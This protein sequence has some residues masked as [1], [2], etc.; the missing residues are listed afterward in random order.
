M[1]I[2]QL[3]YFVAVAE[4]QSFTK[5]ATQFFISQTAITQ[6]IH[7]LE[8][9]IGL[10]LIDRS[11]RPISLTPGGNVFFAEAKSILSHMDMAVWRSREAS[12]GLMG[13]L[14]VG[15]TKGYEQSHLPRW[16]REFHRK[17][18]NILVTCYRNDTDMLAAGLLNQEYDIIFTWDST[19]IR[20][21]EHLRIHHAETVPLYVAMYTSHP[22][23]RR[24]ALT[25]EDLKGETIL[26]MSPS[27]SGD[28]FGDAYYIQ[29]YQ[30]A[31]YQ[32]NILLRTSDY[33]SI[34]MMIAA[35]QAISIV[36]EYCVSKL[37]SVDN[38]SFCPLEGEGETEEVLAVWDDRNTNPALQ[39]FTKMLDKE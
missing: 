11:T 8:E 28:S 20:Q 13:T 5:A 26:F 14:R 1:N 38:I 36:P 30:N 2:N 10:K 9:S 37:K 7:A 29:L 22:F 17:Y 3:K 15:Y 4:H 16:L 39:H 23:S 31:G 32:P 35:E 19:N 6:Q 33:E 24:K 25:R 34:I 18:P 12:T 27:S 21:E